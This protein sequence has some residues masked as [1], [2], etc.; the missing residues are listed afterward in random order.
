MK[1]QWKIR[2]HVSR[3]RRNPVVGQPSVKVVDVQIP[4]ARVPGR[5]AKLLAMKGN[6]LETSSSTGNVRR[7]G[8]AAIAGIALITL[9]VILFFFFRR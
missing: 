1:F 8:A 9:A 5:D 6:E 7:I 3:G 4:P 2:I